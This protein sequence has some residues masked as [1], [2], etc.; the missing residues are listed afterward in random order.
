MSNDKSGDMVYDMADSIIFYYSI[1]LPIIILLI[2]TAI[3]YIV[4]CVQVNNV[5][6]L[7]S[8][9]EKMHNIINN[10]KKFMKLDNI[11]YINNDNLK[12]VEVQ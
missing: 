7:E 12:G 1:V 8:M 4:K 6:I 10:K 5:N 2:L 3:Y 11:Y 9:K